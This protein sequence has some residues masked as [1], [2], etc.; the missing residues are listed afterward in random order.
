MPRRRWIAG[1]ITEAAELDCEL[2]WR[3][4]HR[5]PRSVPGTETPAASV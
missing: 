3:R 4:G 1:A 5:R 2:P